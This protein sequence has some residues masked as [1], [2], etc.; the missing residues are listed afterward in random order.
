LAGG[1]FTHLGNKPVK[2]RIGLRD[3]YGAKYQK[4]DSQQTRQMQVFDAAIV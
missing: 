4:P 2:N 1:F 3:R